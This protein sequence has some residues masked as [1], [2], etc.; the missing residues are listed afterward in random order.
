MTAEILDNKEIS[1]VIL[2]TLLE[3]GTEVKTNRERNNAGM[4]STLHA[5]KL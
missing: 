1:T 5:S 2:K 4:I 3:N